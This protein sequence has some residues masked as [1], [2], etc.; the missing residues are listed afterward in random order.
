MRIPGTEPLGVA[1]SQASSFYAEP[2]EKGQLQVV[3]DDEVSPRVGFD[4]VRYI[5]LIVVGIEEPANKDG[6]ADNQCR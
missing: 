6:G 1:Q 3:F 2:W 5:A 4:P